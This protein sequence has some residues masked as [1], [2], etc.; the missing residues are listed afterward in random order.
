MLTASLLSVNSS[1]VDHSDDGSSSQL[2]PAADDTA[3]LPFEDLRAPRPELPEPSPVAKFAAL[4]AVLVAGLLGGAI[5]YG[6]GDLLFDS[7]TWAAIS[8][9]V[10]AV[11]AA[12]GVG[13]VA[14]LS[15]RASSEWSATRHP[16][17]ERD[18][19]GR[20]TT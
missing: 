11:G 4:T 14:A 6:T 17:D 16:E 19:F 9:L 5:G 18:R 7:A 15:L 2:T 10:L 12:A 8:A 20:I 13:I 3:P 1:G